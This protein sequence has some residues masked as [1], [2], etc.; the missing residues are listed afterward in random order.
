[1]HHVV[2]VCLVGVKEKRSRCLLPIARR[3][4][5]ELG[6]IQSAPPTKHACLNVDINIV[7]VSL[8]QFSLIDIPRASSSGFEL[9]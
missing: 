9:I 5:T 3:K 8:I 6:E 1:M 4:N 7:S 2:L